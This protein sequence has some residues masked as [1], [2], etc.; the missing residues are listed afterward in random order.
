[1]KLALALT[2]SVL[3]AS[4]LAS[5]G[6]P[7]RVPP[8]ALTTTAWPDGGQIPPKYTQAGDQTSPEFK[9]TNTPPGTMSFVFN[10]LD[11]DVSVQKGTEAQPHWIVWNI[12]A[13][14]TGLPEGVKPGAELPDGAHQIS[15]SGRTYRGPGAAATGPLHHYTFEVYALDVTLDVPASTNSQ[16]MGA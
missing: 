7:A 15:A 2:G 3:L 4:S 5:Q 1:M 11:P 13:T 8:M 9:W 6:A 10:M 12:P 14:S 16:A